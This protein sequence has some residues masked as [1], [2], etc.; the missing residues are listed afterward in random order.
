[1]KAALT[2]ML[3]AYTPDNPL[4]LGVPTERLINL[5]EKFGNGGYGILLTG[6]IMVSPTH[7]EKPGNVVV[8]REVDTPERRRQ[9]ERYATA[10]KL[11]GALAIAQLSQPGRQT[12]FAVNPH[13][14]SASD[15][16][17]KKEF[18]GTGYGKP[19]PLTTEQVKTEV[20]DRFVY[21]A[22]AAKEAGFDGVQLHS[23]HGYLLAQFLSPTTNKRTDQYGGSLANR[24]RILLEIYQAIRKEIPAP[25]GFS[26]GI[27]MNSVEF[28]DE[29]LTNDDAAYIAEAVDNIGYDFIELSGGNYENFNWQHS[30][31][32]TKK[33][34]AFF[35]EFA[36]RIKPKI[37]RAA[38]F[39]TG[40]FRTV[41]GMVAAIR[42][43]DTDGIGI[44]RP[45]TAE[46][47]IAKKLLSG[48]AQSVALSHFEYDFAA[49]PM[50][51]NTQMWQA[52]QTSIEE[53]GGDPAYGIMDL[54]SEAAAKE[55]SQA[56]L[57]RLNTPAAGVFEYEPTKAIKA[58]A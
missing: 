7:L 16:Q 52:G 38:V 56:L 19:V 10:C 35:I 27:K 40:G 45:V 55:Y 29:G 30:K 14:F 53:A 24:A 3:C 8:A 23:A 13:P 48:E 17:L 37:K 26:I 1:M 31:E 9:L 11:D 6:N 5:Y 46:P 50:A 36:A 22:K 54:S 34:E 25:T 33:R 57:N 58:K 4:E 32:S 28:Q 21:A 51:C 12:P 47:D 2:E 20:I 43:G 18:R 15:V 42:N 44:G 41:P 49:S 39:L